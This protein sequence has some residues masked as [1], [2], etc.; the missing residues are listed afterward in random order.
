LGLEA[1]VSGIH[2]MSPDVAMK[3]AI[4]AAIGA[5]GQ[6]VLS[7]TEKRI[8]STILPLA[9]STDP[10][11]TARLGMLAMRSPAVGDILNKFSTAITNT[12]TAAQ[13]RTSSREGR[14]TGGA[15]NLM[16]LSKAAKKHVTQSTEGLLDEDDSTV[17]RALEVANKHI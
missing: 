4:G 2:G 8:A 16:A 9:V 1:L 6:T 17:T 3:A 7:A 14:A 12:I 10:K 13:E 5:A 11:D 15:V